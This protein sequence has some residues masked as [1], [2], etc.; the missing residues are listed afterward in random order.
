MNMVDIKEARLSVDGDNLVLR[1][2][3]GYELS[4]VPGGK[5]ED[6]FFRRGEPLNVPDGYVVSETDYSR[7]TPT[8]WEVAHTRG[9]LHGGRPGKRAIDIY[10][11][12]TQSER[13]GFLARGRMFLDDEDYAEFSGELISRASGEYVEDE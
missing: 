1:D 2:E 10:L 8:Q 11:G 5:D 6:G 4:R 13:E 3:S 7:L 12:G 9:G